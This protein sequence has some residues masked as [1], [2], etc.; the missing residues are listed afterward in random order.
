MKKVFRF[1]V[2]DVVSRVGFDHFGSGYLALGPTAKWKYFPQVF[3][4]NY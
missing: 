4:G 1:C 2:G 3:V